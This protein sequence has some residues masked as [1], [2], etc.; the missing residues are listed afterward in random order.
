MTDPC[1]RP[2]AEAGGVACLDRLSHGCPHAGAQ[3]RI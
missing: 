1:H 3:T 2:F